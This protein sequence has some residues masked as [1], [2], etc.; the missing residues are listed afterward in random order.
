MAGANINGLNFN[1]MGG[2]W[3]VGAGD[4]R[5]RAVAPTGANDIISA[6]IQQKNSEATVLQMADG[7]S[8]NVKSGEVVGNVG[9]AVFFEV[10]QNEGNIALKQVF[11]NVNGRS[12]LSTF[13]SLANLEGLMEQ[14][15][16]ARPGDSP[17]DGINADLQARLE[18]R[19][20]ANEAASRLS[21]NIGRVS[22][23]VYGAAV[24]Q[25]AAAGLNIDKIPVDVLSSVVNELE[26]AKINNNSRIYQEL[27]QKMAL[28]SELEPAQIAQILSGEAEI[29][30]D[31]VYKYSV[32]PTAPTSPMAAD[33]WAALQP[34]IDR[35]LAENNL[36]KT[37]ENLERVRLLLE[38]Q[39][40]LTND[41]F[42]KLIFLQN[43]ESLDLQ[44]LIDHAAALDA[45][46]EGIGNLKIYDPPAYEDR[47]LNYLKEAIFRH[48]TRLAMTYE[49]VSALLDTNIEIDLKPQIEALATLKERE[50]EILAAIKG[51]AAGTQ[52]Q[53]QQ[54]VDTLSNVFT[55][56]H[57]DFATMGAIAKNQ[58]EFTPAA[59]EQSITSR[60]YDQNATVA[61]LKYG[62]NP[63]KISH[64]FRPLLEELGLPTDKASIRAAKILTANNMDINAENLNKIKDID[65]KIRDIERHLHP[66]IAANMVAEGLNPSAMHMDE[67]LAYIEDYKEKYDIS[68]SEQL[69]KHIAKMDKEGDVAPE[70]RQQIMDIYRALHKIS[71]NGGAG[72]G[73]AVN[74]GIEMTIENL[75]EF[76]A[77]YNVGKGKRNTLN[78]TAQDGVYHAKHLVSSFVDAAQPAPMAEFVQNESLKD[79]LEISI[80]KL[81]VIAK[82]VAESGLVDKE[83]DL[84]RINAAIKELSSTSREALRTLTALGI[85]ITLSNLRQL[86]ATRGKKLEEDVA[87]LAGSKEIVDSLPKS[88]LEAID[89]IAANENLTEQVE[90]LMDEAMASADTDAVRRIDQMDIVLQNLAFK[91][92]LLGHDRDFSFAMNF[93]G[94]MADVTL[95][96][97]SDNI[98]VADGVTTY[99]S[100]NTAMGEIEGL[101]R[102]KDARIDITLAAETPALSFLKQNQNL[103]GEFFGNLG[104]DDIH[105]TFKDKNAL[106]SQVNAL[107]SLL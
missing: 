22:A 88:D 107:G 39:I 20:K 82:K 100:L 96:L 10:S 19:Q 15:G 27:G 93:N 71:K 87:G 46:G 61:S 35:F 84:A 95:H 54:V 77:T 75:M 80:E 64:Q 90:E 70:I 83:L 72:I 11:P 63:G 101:M 86:K 45:R 52:E 38:S 106:K 73:F 48:E 65:A 34:D 94:R 89:P 49:S 81:E 102:M 76:A 58:V 21:R 51:V 69:L 25:L 13:A 24:A 41:N 53:Y 33:D 47:P 42:D 29:T 105:I 30:L 68:T 103:L 37:P 97:L 6:I 2:G 36:K 55:L 31:N 28:V 59:V 67:I 78:Y 92:M 14:K 5:P 98:N 26:A 17:M 40:P 85:P 18:T 104:T 56:P 50:S 91:K 9:D 99:L 32:S 62:D 66:R 7:Q 23:N 74:A 1:K 8:L 79:P 43:I 16:Y 57:I 44:A 60:K 4:G 3:R 12:F